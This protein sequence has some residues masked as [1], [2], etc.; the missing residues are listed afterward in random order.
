MP[1]INISYPK[2]RAYDS[3]NVPLAS[4]KLFVYQAGTSTDLVNYTDA[5][6]GG[7]NTQPIILDANG[8][9]DLWI[10]ASAKLVLQ[11]SAGTPVWT[12][13]DIQPNIV[14]QDGARYNSALNGSFEVDT[15][16]DG[17]PDNWVITTYTNGTQSLDTAQTTHG[18]QSIKF[19]SGGNGG[20]SATSES[21]FEVE[22]GK[23]IGVSV[24]ILSTLAT[25]RN[26]IKVDW[27]DKSQ[28]FISSSS[29]YDNA[30]TNPTT[31][32]NS[33][34]YSTA[35]ATSTY[36]KLVLIGVH[37]T[38]GTITSGTASWFD[39]VVITGHSPINFFPNVDS[40]VTATDEELN[41]L[42]GPNTANKALQ[43]NASARVPW[44][45]STAFRGCLIYRAA[46]K[47]IAE[48]SAT[49][50]DFTHSSYDTDSFHST[51]VNNSRITIP[52]GS[53]ISYGI[54]K[55]RVESTGGTRSDWE[56]VEGELLK[57]G[58]SFDLPANS[59]RFFQ[60]EDTG[61]AKDIDH[62]ISTPVIPVVEG[63]Y[64]EFQFTQLNTGSAA[65]NFEFW[66]SFEAVG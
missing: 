9:C 56:A 33:L 48:L 3:N 25:A 54:F 37:E 46:A 49:I 4:G 41:L 52:V 44:D 58:G 47:S 38:G 61:A 6:K 42:D 22:Q 14:Q 7:Q 13:D 57:D 51:T 36:A 45:N 21:F 16:G 19:L 63:S 29:L 65:A 1:I 2:F 27:Y 5:D 10:E 43:L 32:T 62:T 53:G 17:A 50:I 66:F 23:Q 64:Y 12:I 40:D 24:S 11:D 59:R 35:P 34:F 55:W 60:F 20:G 26:V 30:T 18:G 8:E 15:D 28:V 39:N 31:F